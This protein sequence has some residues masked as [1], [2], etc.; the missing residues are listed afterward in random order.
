M[1]EKTLQE[2]ARKTK[3]DIDKELQAALLRIKKEKR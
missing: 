2:R 1:D 3:D